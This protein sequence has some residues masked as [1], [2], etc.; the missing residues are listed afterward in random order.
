MP[1]IKLYHHG[2]TA[3]IPPMKNTH[4]RALRGHVVGWS[5]K[6]TRS[7]TAFLRSV[8]LG[9]LDGSGF[10]FTFTLKNCPNTAA[11]WH[12]LRR[13]FLMRLS[14]L[15]MVRGHWVTEWQKR[16]VPHLHGVAYFPISPET[17]NYLT[18]WVKLHSAILNHWLDVA[19]PYGVNSR[20]QNLK[21][22]VDALGWLQYLAKHA[23]RGVSHYQ[24]SSENMPAGWKKTGRVW[25]Y[26][27]DWPIDAP[28]KLELTKEGYFRFR[29]LVRAWRLANARQSGDLYRIQSAR[30]MLQDSDRVRCEVRG[31]SEWIPDHVVLTMLDFLASD[32]YAI[33]N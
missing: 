19:A 1:V 33:T 12:G 4:Q 21:P 23:S 26:V 10:A 5:H 18:E 3:G 11:D 29:R 27:G 2:V 9:S 8:R 20:G 28:V 32:G 22:I 15:G 25:G 24:R 16:G 30:T 14:R 7:N 13:A 17:P 31:V 6:A